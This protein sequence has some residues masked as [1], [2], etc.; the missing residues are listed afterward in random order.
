MT[1]RWWSCRVKGAA[2]GSAATCVPNC[3]WSWRRNCAGPCVWRALRETGLTCDAAQIMAL[4]ELAL[5]PERRHELERSGSV[6]LALDLAPGPGARP[7]RFRLNLF[8]Q[9]RGLA[10]A[11]HKAIRSPWPVR[12]PGLTATPLTLTCHLRTT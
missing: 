2:C 1:A 7:L 6:D 9:Q 5:T 3:G 10:A 11:D 12:A 8:R 4:A